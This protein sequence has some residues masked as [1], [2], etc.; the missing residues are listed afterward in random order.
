[1]AGVGDRHDG[2]GL[3]A[4]EGQRRAGP[5]NVV[6]SAAPTTVA[7]PRAAPGWRWSSLQ[8]LLHVTKCQHEMA[9]SSMQ[10]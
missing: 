3:E 5:D 2:S 10:V 7:A 9:A 6:H 1:M 8:L 4:G